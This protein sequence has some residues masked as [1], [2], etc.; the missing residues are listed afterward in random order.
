MSEIKTH[1]RDWIEKAESRA[2]YLNDQDYAVFEF[3]YI[4]GHRVGQIAA[5]SQCGARQ[6]RR[7][8][9][10]ITRKLTSPRTDWLIRN[11]RVIGESLFNIAA[12]LWVRG[13]PLREVAL[14]MGLSLHDI[15]QAELTAKHYFEYWV[16]L[17]KGVMATWNQKDKKSKTTREWRSP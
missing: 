2:C 9:G 5:I 13:D 12:M 1:H 16:L 3:I 6:V 11:R 10:R 14:K 8:L 15:R 17:N 7:R 4:Y